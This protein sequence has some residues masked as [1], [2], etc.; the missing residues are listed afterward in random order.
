MSDWSKI[1]PLVSRD[2]HGCFYSV[3]VQHDL[4]EVQ[5]EAAGEPVLA[6]LTDIRKTVRAR[7]WGMSFTLRLW[8]LGHEG[9]RSW[10]LTII[11]MRIVM[12]SGAFVQKTNGEPTSL[13]STLV[14]ALVHNLAKASTGINTPRSTRSWS[15]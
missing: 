8:C 9:L 12:G 5:F 14:S 1:E 11:S 3:Y 15:K 7:M 4:V 2:F 6:V 10:G 13:K